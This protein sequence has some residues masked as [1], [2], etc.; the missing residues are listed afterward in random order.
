MG[1]GILYSFVCRKI[2]V[3]A[4]RQFTIVD[5]LCGE[6]RMVLELQSLPNFG[7][8]ELTFQNIPVFQYQRTLKDELKAKKVN[9][10]QALRWLE[11]MMAVRA[12]EEMILALRTGGYPPLKGYEYRGPTHLSI[13]Q[14]ATSVGACAALQ[15]TDCITSTH[16]GHGDGIAK[17]YEATYERDDKSLRD[18]V[19]S[20]AKGLK[21]SKLRDLAIEEHIFRTGAE[22]FG[23]EAGYCKGRGGGMHIADFTSGHLGA[24]AIVG[25]GVP[26]ATG[27]AYSARCSRSGQ[28]VVCFAGD[29]AFNN[30]VVLESLNM[31]TMAQ[32]T[33]KLAKKR[34]G[35]PI[36][37]LIVNNQ[38][39]MTGR[40]LGEVS[41][42]DFM[43]RRAAGY[44][45]NGMEAEVVNGMD[46]LAVYDS[47]RRGVELCRKGKGPVLRELVTYRYYGHSL[48]D[49]RVEYRSKQE[50]AAWKKLDPID[51]FAKQ[52]VEAG[53]LK[54]N[55]V[56]KLRKN[57]E[58][59]QAR[60]AVRAAESADPDAKEVLR[61]VFTEKVEK[62]VPKP[63]AKVKTLKPIEKPKR[64]SGQITVRDAIKE[65][66]ME[67]MAR[68]ARVI[69]YGEDVAD[70]G[71]AFKIT[72]GLVE[73]FGR[74]RVFN[75]SISEAAI[76]GTG[77]GAAM[78]GMRPV[79]E[80]MYSDFEF[81]A[82]DQ[83]NNQAAKWSYMSGG[84]NC[85]PM[86]VRTSTGAGKGYGGQHSQGLESH[87]CHTPGLRVVVP[88]NAYDFKGLLKT[89]I[90]CNDPVVF[91]ESQLLYND[92]GEVPE[93]EYLIPFG[94][95]RTMRQGKDLTI[96]AWSYLVG[97]AM[98]AAEKL[99]ETGVDV[100]II[101]PRTLCPFDYD[102]VV[103][104][105]KRTGKLIVA[106]QACR[107][108]SFTG[109]VVA[110]VQ[111]RVF[112]YL[113]APIGRVGALDG[114]SPQ[115][116]VL[117]QTYLPG[118]DDIVAEANKLVNL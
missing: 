23:K 112:D 1:M 21:G 75:S 81:M 102:T 118:V 69:V 60:A 115:A 74:D 78:T 30:G 49:P 58:K 7:P 19:G 31:A 56:E 83:L 61:Y 22:L 52:M 38:Y 64:K 107:T 88:S 92:K 59:R 28:V 80:L 20:S 70:Y 103:D 91:V 117:E 86:V 8:R 65:A 6:C 67:E 13:G 43:A 72:K 40:Q 76:I 68:D 54:K 93:E 105:V 39:G 26:I 100:E 109:E 108:G 18:W 97:E 55:E 98:K 95:A 44:S 17:G 37:Y 87:S 9:K 29:G 82:G 35:V 2:G 90:R 3:L 12:F 36:M 15:L 47:V 46:V 50:E 110:Q 99:A 25:G 84:H 71:G 11:S 106:S 96:V 10:S 32:F 57:V 51:A 34:F 16:R 114:I 101:D 79:V 48:G 53:V 113:D 104:S 24:N 111:E 62:D 116:Y 41:G 89:S 85:V 45:D 27:A 42:L 94:E 5:S 66:L 63:F 14:E 4:N 73:I 33:N 77:V